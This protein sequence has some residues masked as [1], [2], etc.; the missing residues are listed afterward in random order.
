MRC[1]TNISA[2]TGPPGP[3]GQLGFLGPRGVPG[4]P[5]PPGP[6]G[7]GGANAQGV[8]RNTGLCYEEKLKALEFPSFNGTEDTY[9]LW[10]E[11]GDTY[12]HY[13]QQSASV[14]DLGRVATFNFTGIAAIWWHGLTQEER[15]ERTE[16]WPML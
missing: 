5:G 7:Q 13:G 2:N 6:P 16:H 15:N 10:A 4:P 9:G 11:K 14:E 8:N 1:W 12:F 3:P